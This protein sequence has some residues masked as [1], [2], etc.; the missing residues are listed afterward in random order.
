MVFALLFGILFFIY[1]PSCF[2][3]NFV[4]MNSV[5][6]LANWLVNWLANWLV[7]WLVDWLVYWLVDG[8]IDENID[9]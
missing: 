3:E 4:D 7:N 5:W 9:T 2:L 1:Y 6:F 8:L